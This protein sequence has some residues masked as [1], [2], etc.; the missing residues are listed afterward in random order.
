[1]RPRSLK[2]T[3]DSFLDQRNRPKAGRTARRLANVLSRRRPLAEEQGIP[4]DHDEVIL[5]RA[6]R[7]G[8]HPEAARRADVPLLSL[9]PRSGPALSRL[10]DLLDKPRIV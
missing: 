7:D 1:M 6:G 2:S 8:R 9:T 10:V 3:C 4:F 5:L